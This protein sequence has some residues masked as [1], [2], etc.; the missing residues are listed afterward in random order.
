VDSDSVSGF[1]SECCAIELDGRVAKPELYRGY[2]AW[3]RE[4]NRQPLSAMRFNRR[5]TSVIASQSSCEPSTVSRRG[6]D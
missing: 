2:G 6:T 5:L 1:L 3:C 4:N